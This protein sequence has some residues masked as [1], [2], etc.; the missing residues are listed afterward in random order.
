MLPPEKRDQYKN[1]A[2]NVSQPAQS[3]VQ[4][5]TNIVPIDLSGAMPQ[6]SQ[7]GGGGVSAPP[8]TQKNGPSV[9]LL[10]SANTDNFLVL[11]S[12]MVYN[13]VDG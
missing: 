12:R 10:P 1:L 8:S 9:P 6:Q 3:A 11:Y 13:I 7:G 4:S 2:T 5:Q